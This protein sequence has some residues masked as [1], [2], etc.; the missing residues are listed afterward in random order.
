MILHSVI[1]CTDAAQGPFLVTKHFLPALGK[2]PLAKVINISSD[3]G[4]IAGMMI[5][6]ILHNHVCRYS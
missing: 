1:E 6:L 3:Y 2:A 4:S 5:F